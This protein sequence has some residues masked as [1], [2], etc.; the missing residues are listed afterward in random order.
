MRLQALFAFLLAVALP[1]AV[2]ARKKKEAED[3]DKQAHLVVKLKD[4]S[5][6]EGALT[7][8]WFRWPAKTIN[9]NFKMSLADGTEV[10]YT[11]HQID[12]IFIPRQDRR[13][14]SAYIPVPRLRN[15]NNAVKWIVEC[16]P[17]SEHGE[18]LSY[19]SRVYVKR[20]NKTYWETAVTHCMRFECDSVIYPFYYEKNG[21]FNLSVMKNAL[22]QS[23]PGAVE[24]INN[25]FKANKKQKKELVDSPELFLEAYEE[26][27]RT[28]KQ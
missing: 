25:Y 10:E 23:R 15:K 16:G 18:I 26:Y 20:G 22:K 17:A 3:N 21:G 2:S 9:E 11:S 7:K 5:V 12:S 13:F 4:A 19:M 8:S 24:Y 28:Q 14:T 27:L 1:V 6:V